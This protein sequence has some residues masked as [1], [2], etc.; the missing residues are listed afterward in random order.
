M[1]GPARPKE[2]E[3]DPQQDRQ[4]QE[5]RLI[6]TLLESAP[7]GFFCAETDE[8]LTL[9]YA[10]ESFYTMY[11]YTKEKMQQALGGKLARCIYPEDLETL[12]KKMGKGKKAS[13]TVEGRVIREDGTLSWTMMSAK[14]EPIGERHVLYGFTTDITARRQ[15]LQDLRV[16][17]ERYRIAL[18][19]TSITIFEYDLATKVLER[20][21]G[22]SGR[23]QIPKQLKG[24]PS[25]LTEQ[26][27]IL[28][29]YAK[30]L[31]QMFAALQGGAQ[32]A[33]CMVEARTEGDKT[34]WVQISFTSIFNEDG[35]IPIKAIGVFTDISDMKAAEARF[36]QEVQYRNAVIADALTAYKVDIDTDRITEDEVTEKKVSILKVI[37]LAANCQYSEFL[38]RWALRVDEQD[39]QK[40]LQELNPEALRNAYDQGIYEVEC[41]Y[42]SLN[43]MDEK[44]WVRTIIHLTK[45]P[46]SGH[47]TGFFYVKDIHEKKLQE[48]AILER[49]QRD[50]LTGLLNR[51]AI[52]TRI[53]TACKYQ[54][55]QKGRTCLLMIDVDNFKRI[56]DQYGHAFG[57]KVLQM[58]A[59]TMIEAFGMNGDIARLGGDEFMVFLCAPAAKRQVETEIEAF[60]TRLAEPNGLFPDGK[61]LTCSIGAAYAEE[62]P[63]FS[64]LYENADIALY[65]AKQS[66]KNCVSFF[67]DAWRKRASFTSALLQMDREWLIDE[68]EEIVYVSDPVTYDMI[69]MN[70]QGQLDYG[71][72]D[73]MGKK[74]YEV[75]MGSDEPC[76]FCTNDRLKMDEYY[77]WEFTNPRV[78]RHYII[79]DKLI[80][81]NGKPARMEFA[82]DVSEKEQVSKA[83]S[84]KLEAANILIDCMTD[85]S[86]EV[87]LQS[88]IQ[89]VL[90]KISTYYGA[91]R[92]FILELDRE[93]MLADVTYEWSNDA[94]LSQK[95]KLHAIPLD[96]YPEWRDAIQKGQPL[97]LEDLEQFKASG[98]AISHLLEGQALHSLRA[99]PI[100][101]KD[102]LS[103]FVGIDDPTCH[104]D[105]LSLLSNLAYMLLN[106]IAKRRMEKEQVYALDHDLLTGLFNRNSYL[107]YL[108]SDPKL[109]ALGVLVG[110]I[111]G[112]KDY[113][114]MR[115]HTFGDGIIQNAAALLREAFPDALIYRFSGDEFVVLQED[116][117]LAAFLAQV[118]R[119]KQLLADKMDAG[120]MSL[121]HT[122]SDTDID[123]DALVSHASERMLIEKQAHYRQEDTASKANRPKERQLLLEHLAKGNF[124]LYLQPKVAAQTGALTGAE[125]LVRYWD[126]KLGII[127]PGRFIPLL[128]Q[129]KN[130]RY[131]DYH[132]FE[133]VCRQLYKWMEEG[134]PLLP[135]SV[136]F[137]RITLLEEELIPTLE[138]IHDRWPVP[139]EY[140]ELE[141]T[142][143]IGQMERDIVASISRDLQSHGYGIALDDFGSSYTNM[144]ML[145]SVKFNTLKL[146]RSLVINLVQNKNSR[147]VAGC[148]LELCRQL[149]VA[150][151]AEGVETPQQLAVLKELGCQQIQGFLYSVPVPVTEFESRWLPR[152]R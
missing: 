116:L 150:S 56:N 96:E 66:G 114:R 115:G 148:V 41:D 21:G 129:A 132:M 138:R 27:F 94:S 39:R 9:L 104:E 26:G 70:R 55:A 42:R 140:I 151:V 28:P 117:S 20:T 60:R 75:I 14:V 113:N 7:A 81:W 108:R 58:L 47:L 15:T 74:C 95:E 68:L 130:I 82:I 2:E 97:I 118:K 4:A 64:K 126:E 63:I 134:R 93:S 45:D 137:S 85:L 10:N 1:T 147:I 99:V 3:K 11:G 102:L 48:L 98:K 106:E 33:S 40:F 24:A 100:T 17:L 122:W 38:E 111:N 110:D 92:A 72:S 109:H 25:S 44:I 73:F 145:S 31:E 29:Q 139:R 124:R 49:A 80:L 36:Q 59:N 142:E 76:P 43:I 37:G 101:A 87:S 79:K 67:E 105:D 71:S 8:E 32:A 152:A 121:G 149:K 89:A 78:Q 69:Y 61:S 146:D 50:S 88:A 54:Q 62:G 6:R 84:Q 34:G 135:I 125:A 12:H 83:L 131:L 107:K 127:P 52:Q 77:V 120:S 18:E 103:G 51:T 5:Y 141:I 35:T 65:Q 86:T 90:K 16:S 57:D 144:A 136:N 128:E 53:D 19:I 143:S 123:I 13:F 133:A 91:R 112:L 46:E 119:G 23:Y 30:T 22:P